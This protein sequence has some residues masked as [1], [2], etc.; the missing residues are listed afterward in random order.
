LRQA[1]SN[2]REYGAVEESLVKH[3]RRPESDEL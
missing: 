1:Q 2:F 3:V